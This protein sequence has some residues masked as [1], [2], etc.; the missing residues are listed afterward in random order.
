LLICPSTCSRT[1]LSILGTLS[2]SASFYIDEVFD[3]LDSAIAA[4]FVVLRNFVGDFVNMWTWHPLA[5]R[6][7]CGTVAEQLVHVFEIEAFGLGLETPEEYSVEEITDHEDKVEFL[8]NVSVC[9]RDPW[10]C[11]ATYPANRCDRNRGN[12]ADHRVESER[13]H[14][15]PW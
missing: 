15:S 14:C 1:S 3:V 5:T 7:E 4:V 6:H 8:A 10:D 9:S 11:V 2:S 12:L 13:G